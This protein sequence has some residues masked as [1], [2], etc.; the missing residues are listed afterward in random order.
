MIAFRTG[1][2]T[3]TMKKI[4]LFIIDDE[5][6]VL[7]AL[8]AVFRPNKR[9]KVRAHATVAAARADVEAFPPQ[10]LLCDY[11]MPECDGLEVVRELKRRFPHLRSILLTGQM[12]DEHIVK[13]LEQ[14]LIDLYIA[15][16]WNQPELEDAVKRLA[17]E[18]AKGS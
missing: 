15:K 18:V 2:K 1:E 7:N 6:E 13:G 16:P 11:L 17:R 8:A 3:G 4:T 10:L 14:G 9:Y 12:F 5:K